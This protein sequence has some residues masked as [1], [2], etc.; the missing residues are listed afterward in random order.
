MLQS[1]QIPLQGLSSFKPVNSISQFGAASKPAN[2]AF[3]CIQT[4]DTNMEPDWS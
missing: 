1:I 3:N 4:I 2:D